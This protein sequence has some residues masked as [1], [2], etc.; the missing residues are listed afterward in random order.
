MSAKAI[1]EQTGKE[2]LYKYICTT[3]AIQN[4]FKYARVTPDTDWARLLQDHPWLLSQVS[5]PSRQAPPPGP[6][7]PLE[8]VMA[9]G[10]PGWAGCRGLSAFCVQPCVPHAEVLRLDWNWSAGVREAALWL[11]TMWPG[12]N[13][14]TSLEF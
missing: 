14:F 6:D 13:H 4:R 9:D 8:R 12:A 11:L 10:L 3:S 2:L 7:V 1:S 5:P